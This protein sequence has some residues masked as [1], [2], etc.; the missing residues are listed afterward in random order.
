MFGVLLILR[1]KNGTCASP[2]YT[3]SWFCNSEGASHALPQEM[4]LIIMMIPI[5]YSSVAKSRKLSLVLLSWLLSL[6]MIIIAIFVSESH[7]SWH[8]VVLYIPFSIII[9]FENH[10]QNMTLHSCIRQ[11][12][13]LLTEN[14]KYAE[15]AQTELRHMIA[16]VAHDLKTV[17]TVIACI[18]PFYPP[19]PYCVLFIPAVVSV[20]D[21]RGVH[22][23]ADGPRHTGT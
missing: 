18:S 9:I 17:S 4:I 12:Q 23:G 16:N 20:Y 8:A 6:A 5:F 11:Q 13:A 19:P 10:R 3:H 22:H 7:R 21:G 15:D 1:V 14:V 2:L